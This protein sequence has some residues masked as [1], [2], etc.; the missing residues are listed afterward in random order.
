M[1]TLHRLLGGPALSLL[2]PALFSAS[3]VSLAAEPQQH[4]VDP[5]ALSSAVTQHV[6]QEDANRAAIREALGRPE[7]KSV[8]AKAGI[9]LNRADAAVGT[10]SGAS[11]DQAAAA[12]RQVADSLAGGAST[13][14][15]SSETV[16][17][18]LLLVLLIILAIR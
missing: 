6:A 2:V 14:V 15:I 8:A 9:D 12:A 5:S 3:V 7:V 10:L 4:L 16:I 11:L 18:I 13:E 17:I 1:R